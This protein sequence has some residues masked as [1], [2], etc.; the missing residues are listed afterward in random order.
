MIYVWAGV[1]FNVN[2]SIALKGQYYYSKIKADEYGNGAWRGLENDSP[3]HWRV[4]ADISQ[5]A[6]R[7]TSLWLEYGQY[8]AGFISPTGINKAGSVFSSAWLPDSLDSDM[9][10]WRVGLGQKWN[11][12]WATKLFYFGYDP[13]EGDSM[14]E[15]GLGVQYTYTP[16]VK[17]GLNFMQADNGIDDKDNIVR[18]RTQ[19][20]F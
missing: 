16:A 8:D 2:D 11:D 7:F 15:W 5:E 17:F 9:K 3:K 1:R 6:L 14:T 20:T 18:F 10:Y 13:K 12:K 4:I 19:V